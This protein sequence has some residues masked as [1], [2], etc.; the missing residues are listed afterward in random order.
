LEFYPDVMTPKEEY[1][2]QVAAVRNTSTFNTANLSSYGIVIIEEI[3]NRD[4]SRILVGGFMKKADAE[5]KLAMMKK[6]SK[7]YSSAFIVRYTDGIRN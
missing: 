5:R 7:E 2:I 3:E 4:L 1:R 6:E